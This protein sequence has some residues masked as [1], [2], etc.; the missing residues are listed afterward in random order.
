MDDE[1]GDAF[2][3]GWGDG[4]DL[5][6]DIDEEH[7]PETPGEPD[8]DSI[9]ALRETVAKL[10]GGMET[11]RAELEKTSIEL[12]GKKEEQRELEV[13]MDEIKRKAKE[14]ITQMQDKLRQVVKQKN[15]LEA[16][17]DAKTEAERAQVL[18]GTVTEEV[19]ELRSELE[20]QRGRESQWDAEKLQ[21]LGRIERL[22]TVEAGDGEETAESL[23]LAKV[24]E[25]ERQLSE[26]Q[27]EVEQA[28]LESESKVGDV[29]RKAKDRVNQVEARLEAALLENK[30]LNDK[31]RE[32]D[33]AY[34]LQNDKVVKYKQLMSQANSRIEEGEGTI[35]RLNEELSREQALHAALQERFDREHASN[36]A[37]RAEFHITPP[38]R[39]ELEMRGG[40]MTAVETEDDVWCLVR[41]PHGHGSNGR[42]WLLSQLDVDTKPVPLERRWKGEV[43]ALRAQIVLFRKKC[44]DIQTEFEAYKQKAGVALQNA[45]GNREKHLERDVESLGEQ[46][47]AKCIELDQAQKDRAKALDELSFS[48]RRVQEQVA[49]RC[50]LERG[51]EDR[52]RE[53]I[54]IQE[55]SLEASKKQFDE[56][57]LTLETKWREKE[58]S[59]QQD[60]LQSRGRTEAQDEEIEGLRRRVRSLLAAAQAEP[61]EA[62]PPD[63]TESAV[64]KRQLLVLA[65]SSPLLDAAPLPEVAQSPQL[66][67]ELGEVTGSPC[68]EQV[69]ESPAPTP[70]V[71]QEISESSG[72]PPP[73]FSP[74]SVVWHDLTNARAQVRQLEVTLDAERRKHEE[75]RASCEALATDVRE[76]KLQQQ[77]QGNMAQQRQMEYIRNV[78]R[79]FVENMPAGSVE[80]EQLISV[81]MAFFQFPQTEAKA[82]HGKRQTK[83]MWSW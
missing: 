30:E 10:E 64:P 77:L 12:D 5:D 82:I 36:E 57:K 70:D 75:A 27:F 13:K 80:S 81:L 50:E 51:M 42:W 19:A 52:V 18:E 46:L 21:L 61:T 63:P 29:V 67:S 4:L 6:M 7:S 71:A 65:D 23:L 44:D 15:D 49:Q 17:L 34:K 38:T 9:T 14:H 22:S 60:L 56:E 76:M 55:E 41:E 53:R 58:R 54:H 48:R 20:Q 74:Q 40:V 1:F 37:E 32:A 69:V 59:Y 24:R 78:F 43:S 73:G 83:S 66:G 68:S 31:V 3:G 11:V 79:K 16:E 28:R 33:E 62:S 35:G 72:V 39:E 45:A 8:R 47:H 25:T 26:A 2:A